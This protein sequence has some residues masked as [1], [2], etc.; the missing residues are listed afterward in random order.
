[1]RVYTRKPLTERFW[2]KV[3]IAG[4]DDCWPWLGMRQKTGY[5][6][7]REGGRHGKLLRTHVLALK[8]HTNE[9]ANGRSALHSCDNPPCCNPK[10]LRWGTAMDNVQ[11]CINRGRRATRRPK[12]CVS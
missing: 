1:M 7:V 9:E 6:N 3:A 5:G 8:L 12:K 11:D 2:S 4:E 10:H